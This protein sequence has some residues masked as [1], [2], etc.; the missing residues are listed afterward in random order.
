[1]MSPVR[2][3]ILSEPRGSV[4]DQKT[5][6]IASNSMWT[7]FNRII[8]TSVLIFM[9]G[10]NFNLIGFFYFLLFVLHTYAYY[11]FKGKSQF[12]LF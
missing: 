9:A 12:Q 10:S 6:A 1:M 4:V 11:T 5:T 7:R 8:G 2:N 3:S